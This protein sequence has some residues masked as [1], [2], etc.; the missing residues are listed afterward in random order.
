MFGGQLSNMNE[1]SQLELLRS[2]SGVEVNQIKRVLL[3]LVE[4]FVCNSIENQ[5]FEVPYIGKLKLDIKDYIEDGK[6]KTEVKSLTEFS[7]EFVYNVGKFVDA[8]NGKI[9]I[10]DVPLVEELIK[11]MNNDLLDNV[12]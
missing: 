5:E 11:E 1:K 6:P 2:Y 3:A 4:L 8:N 12:K 9:R 7:D 10:S